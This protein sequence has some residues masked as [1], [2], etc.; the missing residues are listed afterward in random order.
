MR[1]APL[2]SD[3]ARPGLV[4]AFLQSSLA[5]AIIYTA[6]AEIQSLTGW[7]MKKKTQKAEKTALP[8]R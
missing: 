6:C 2:P 3:K 7:N 8:R 4:L 1:A 5:C